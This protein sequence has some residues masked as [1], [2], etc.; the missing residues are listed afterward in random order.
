[1]FIIYVR[2][3]IQV[4]LE[5]SMDTVSPNYCRSKGEQIALNVD[6]T[7]YDETNT[8]SAYVLW[9]IH[10]SL[11]QVLLLVW[12]FSFFP[13]SSK[14]MD[15]Q[16]FSSIQA[17]TNTSRYAAAVFRK[18]L[19]WLTGSAARIVHCGTMFVFWLCDLA[20]KDKNNQPLNHTYY[21]ESTPIRVGFMTWLFYW[22]RKQVSFTSHLWL[23][24]FRW[25]PA[26]LTWTRPTTKP[27][28][29]RRPMKV[30][31]LFLFSRLNSEKDYLVYTVYLLFENLNRLLLENL[32]L[33][34]TEWFLSY[35]MPAYRTKWLCVCIRC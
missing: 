8:Y 25:G 11:I 34:W 24:F 35:S 23:E 26:S 1:M 4:E 5:I 17:T 28:R 3:L 13:L 10:S 33:S 16:T 7:G 14:M 9:F 27:E 15:K 2:L 32:D 19:T 31:L 12:L 18:G 22:W 20:P 30:C 21:D 6:G 29:G